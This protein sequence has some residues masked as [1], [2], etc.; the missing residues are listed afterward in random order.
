MR[1]W[2]AGLALALGLGAGAQAAPVNTG[3]VTLELVAASSGAPGKTV[4]VALRQK[5]A[6]GWHTY[7]RNPG[8]SGE[9]TQI[10]WSLPLGYRAGDIT[11]PAPRRLPLGPLMN[12]GYEGE[13]LLASPV[14]VPASARAGAT[15]NIAATV[16]LLVCKDICI[17][18]QGRVALALPVAKAPAPDANW[19]GPITRTLADAPRPGGLTAVM[20]TTGGGLKLAITGKAVTGPAV[21]GVYFFPYAGNVIDHAAAQRVERGAQGVTLTLK[22]GS[23]FASGPA[24]AEISGVLAVGAKAYEVTA[25]RGPLPATARGLGPIAS[26]GGG[27]GGAQVAANAGGAPGADLGLGAALAFAF[28]GG[29]VLNLMPCVFPI[30]S[31]KVIAVAR[32]SASPRA[33][34]IE[35]AAFAIGVLAAFLAL[36]LALILAKAA[37][38]QVGWGFQLQSPAVVAG[39]ALLMLLIGLNLSG[40]FEAGL[41]LQAAGSGADKGGPF[42]AL[43]TGALAVVVAA[44]C[45]APF[46]AGAIG[47]ALTQSAWAALLVFAALGV[48]FAAPFLF[49]TLVPALA[50]LLPRP[51]GWMEGLKKVLAFPMYGA[52]AWLLWVLTLQAGS[53]AMA[54]LLA[55]GV[56]LALA[57]WLYGAG[58]RA[59]M[60]GGRG[61]AAYGFGGLAAVAA[62]ALAVG[63][64]QAQAPAAAMGGGPLQAEAWS[65]AR[66]GQ[67]QAEGRPVFVDFTAAWCVTC[68]VNERVALSTGKVKDAFV[69]T[70]TVYL[71]ADWTRR[72]PAI[73]QALAAQGRAGVPLY[74]L[75]GKA[76]GAPVIL[77]QLLTEDMVAAAL[78]KAAKG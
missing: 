20:A 74:L 37:G 59:R 71:K 58:Q 27:G 40:V 9:A 41:S 2:I 51:G 43:L 32:H 25:R 1:P 45:T 39:L 69:R 47:F 38:S 54:A 6:P 13:V 62:A 77:P 76:G 15:A 48:G 36:A 5:I 64:A 10:K 35:A 8:D 50:R 34:R 70:R 61:L 31:M 14:A 55:A 19:G 57:A 73:A 78:D 67:L 12:Y 16:N 18:E 21:R 52:A 4:Q 3:H 63:A 33:A 22:P 72:D 17:P 7:W 53:T 28:L 42:G 29:V 66:I 68:Q 56:T 46:M 60:G 24:P 30:L 44:P 26:I 75:Y 49:L 65:P 11:W 23:A